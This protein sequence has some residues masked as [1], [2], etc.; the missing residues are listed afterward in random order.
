MAVVGCKKLPLQR[1][2]PVAAHL[3]IHQVIVLY[4]NRGKGTAVE[5]VILHQKLR[6]LFCHR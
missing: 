6:F 5:A 1:Q 4:G 3:V 2:E